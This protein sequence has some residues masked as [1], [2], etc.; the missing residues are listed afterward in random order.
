MV[1]PVLLRIWHHPHRHDTNLVRDGVSLTGGPG[2]KQRCWIQG[3]HVWDVAHQRDTRKMYREWSV[4]VW[5]RMGLTP[6][7]PPRTLSRPCGST[8]TAV[9]G[10]APCSDSDN[11]CTTIPERDGAI[12]NRP[13]RRSHSPIGTPGQWPP[14]TVGMV[15]VDSTRTA[16]NV[17]RTREPSIHCTSTCRRSFNNDFP[18]RA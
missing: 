5:R 4:T 2:T 14:P 7:T 9:R 18:R 16:T 17:K 8:F 3:T 10:M 12:G 1:T 15:P 6:D 13:G 11:S